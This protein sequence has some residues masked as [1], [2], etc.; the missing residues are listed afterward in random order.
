MVNIGL[1]G[2]FMFDGVDYDCLV[3]IVNMLWFIG[4]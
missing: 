2:G 4:I 3:V 1:I